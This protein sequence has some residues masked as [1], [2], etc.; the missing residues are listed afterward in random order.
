MDSLNDGGV[1]LTT[2]V[3]SYRR[4]FISGHVIPRLMTIPP[5]LTLMPHLMAASDLR[6]YLKG[7]IIVAICGLPILVE[8]TSY[9]YLGQFQVY[10]L[11]SPNMLNCCCCFV[12]F[13]YYANP[14]HL[15]NV[16]YGSVYYLKDLCSVS[17]L[18]NG[19]I[20]LSNFLRCLG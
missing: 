19:C 16:I 14:A 13:E 20:L 17:R 8:F 5:G 3:K 6:P 12:A 10:C 9:I 15:N 11:H 1:C 18:Y 2:I 4:N 7:S